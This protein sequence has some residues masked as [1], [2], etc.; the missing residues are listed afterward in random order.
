MNLL[1]KHVAS[2]SSKEPFSSVALPAPAPLANPTSQC[3]Q[4]CFIVCVPK[5]MS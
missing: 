4:R 3:V 2:Q 5:V 1:T